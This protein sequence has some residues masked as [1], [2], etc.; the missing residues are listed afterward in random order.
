MEFLLTLITSSGWV[1]VYRGEFEK[2]TFLLSH[3][4]VNVIM[5]LLGGKLLILPES[6]MER[7]LRKESSLAAG[8]SI[9]SP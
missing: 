4:L 7:R 1:A 5:D 8:S 6:E 2:V 3:K 9:S